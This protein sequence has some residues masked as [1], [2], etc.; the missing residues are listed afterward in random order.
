MNDEYNLKQ[1]RKRIIDIGHSVGKSGAHFGSSLSLVEIIY[2]IYSLF[3]SIDHR[4]DRFILSKGHGALGLY[5][6]LEH[7]DLMDKHTIEQFEVNGSGVFA[8]A[9]KCSINNIEFSGGSLGLGLPFAIGIALSNMRKLNDNKVFVLLGDGECDE[10]IIWESLM[11]AAHTELSNLIVI[12]DNNK[13]QSDGEKAK[14]LQ[15]NNFF[16]KFSSFGFDTVEVDGHDISDITNSILSLG[17]LDSNAPKAI[18][19]NTI[20]GKGVSFMEQTSD[21][22]HGFLSDLLYRQAIEELS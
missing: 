2:S 11:F 20:K 1:I 19:A 7:F 15:N 16:N 13:F 12:V 18:I 14:I 17:S 3:K 6:V 10:G 9:S 21:W 22:H 5:A 4:N 8:H